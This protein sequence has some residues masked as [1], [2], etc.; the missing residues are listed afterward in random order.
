[1]KETTATPWIDEETQECIERCTDCHNVCT[2][3]IT[4]CLKQGGAYA[5][6]DLV[7]LLQDCAQHC[8]TSTDFMLRGS[9]FSAPVCGLCARICDA[10]ADA[11][12]QFGAD[13]QMTLCADTCR[14]CA[15]CCRRMAG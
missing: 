1:M 11:C 13:R 2:E 10:C 15:A 9:S 5:A 14:R 8:A 7:R 6:L 12:D 3:T 4:Y